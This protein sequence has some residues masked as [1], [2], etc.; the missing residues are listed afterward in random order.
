FKWRRQYLVCRTLL[1]DRNFNEALTATTNLLTLAPASGEAE[2]IAES[3]AIRARILEQL[4]ELEAAIEAYERNLAPG[5]PAARR[6]QALLKTVQLTLAQDK[7]GE[8]AQKLE[9]FLLQSPEEKGTDFALL[10]LG[11]LYLKQHITRKEGVTNDLQIAAGYFDRLITNQPPGPLRG[12]ALLQRGWCYWVDGKYPEAQGAFRTAVD[13]LPAAEDQAVARMKLGDCLFQLKDYTNAMA[14]YRMV[15][16]RYLDLPR[17][18]D[19]LVEVAWH[20]LLRAGLEVR[21]FPAATEAIERILQEHATGSVADYSL[22][23]VGQNLSAAGKHS[24]ARTL[25]GRFQQ[26]FSNSPLLPDVELA[27]ARTLV[28]EEQFGA[29]IQRYEGWLARYTNHALVPKALY[30]LARTQFRAGNDTNALSLFTNFVAR[31]PTNELAPRAQMWIGNHYYTGNDFLNAERSFQMLFQNTNWSGNPLAYEARMM[32]GRA[33]FARQAYSDAE[34][35]FTNLVNDRSCPVEIVTEAFFAY[36]DTLTLQAENPPRLQKY[37]EAREAFSRIPQLFPSS[38]LAPAARGRI[39]DCYLQLGAQ[40]PNLY[41]SAAEAYREAMK[42]PD[43]SIRSQAEVGLGKVLEKQAALRPPPENKP[44]LTEARDRYLN[45]L[46]GANL[47]DAEKP[48]SFWVKEAGFAA[49]RL[50]EDQQEWAVAA[51]IYKTLLKLLPPLQNV[52]EKRLERAVEQARLT[53]PN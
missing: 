46:N 8:A 25:F 49:A 1:L 22:L 14:Q 41:D 3:I 26:M 43:V 27:L 48:S 7:L 32:A 4:G 10:A 31:F 2:F 34:G 9:T 24:Q 6:R 33:A 12:Q 35:Y 29:A 20:Q 16:T 53:R 21:D 52:I 23:L 11:E 42:S 19:T 44:L 13:S 17:V 36:G 5:T 45:V 18:R 40:D 47:G 50:A 38:P 28:E 37:S 30:N 51:N 39:G 15:A